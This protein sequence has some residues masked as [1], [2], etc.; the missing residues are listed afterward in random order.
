MYANNLLQGNGKESVWV[1]VPHVL[2]E[3]KRQSPQIAQGFD[4]ARSYTGFGEA[5]AIK[6]DGGVDALQCVL[7]TPELQR[8]YNFPGQ[9]FEFVIPD[10]P[11]LTIVKTLYQIFARIR[12]VDYIP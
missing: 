2:L 6:G 8:F 10:H 3:G 11:V 12:V 1:I 7:Q 5:A 9:R 4:H